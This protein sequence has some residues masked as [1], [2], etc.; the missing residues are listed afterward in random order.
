MKKS[1]FDYSQ[2]RLLRVVWHVTRPVWEDCDPHLWIL[3]ASAGVG[4]C[5][6]P[7]EQSFQALGVCPDRV[8]HLDELFHHIGFTA[9]PLPGR[10]GVIIDVD[11]SAEKGLDPRCD[12]SV[13]L[14]IGGE[15]GVGDLVVVESVHV[16]GS[17][18]SDQDGLGG[19]CCYFLTQLR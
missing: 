9:E 19:L 6:G 17:Q 16:V 2:M 10:A 15:N 11:G 4:A 5:D 7:P 8:S 13:I 3:P 12:D 1:G 14:V 18:G